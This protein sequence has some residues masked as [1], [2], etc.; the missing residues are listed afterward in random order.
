M[1]EPAPW[2]KWQAVSHTVEELGCW[3]RTKRA[4][5]RKYEKCRADELASVGKTDEHT[6]AMI[7]RGLKR[8]RKIR[9]VLEAAKELLEEVQDKKQQME[10]EVW[11]EMEEKI[12]SSEPEKRRSGTLNAKNWQ[13]VQS[14]TTTS[15][16]LDNDGKRLSRCWVE[17]KT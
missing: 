6:R 2:A 3:Q 17:K 10:D 8:L 4:P 15:D 16:N 13:M 7:T 11:K 9:E 5:E 14:S 1:E 12:P